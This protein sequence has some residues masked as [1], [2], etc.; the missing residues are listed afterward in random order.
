M[1]HRTNYSVLEGVAYCILL[2]IW[3]PLGFVRYKTF[4]VLCRKILVLILL[5]LVRQVTIQGI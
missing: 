2:H 1:S 4:L 3:L 5:N